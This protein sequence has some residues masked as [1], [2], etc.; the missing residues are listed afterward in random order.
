MTNKR[1]KEKIL[2]IKWSA[3]LGVALYSGLFVL[4]NFCLIKNC[5]DNAPFLQNFSILVWIIATMLFAY[6]Y[7]L[8]LTNRKKVNEVENI[9]SNNIV[10]KE[11]QE[12]NLPEVIALFVIYIPVIVLFVIVI[13]NDTYTQTQVTSDPEFESFGNWANILFGILYISEASKKLFEIKQRLIKQIRK[14]LDLIIILAASI[15]YITYVI[16]FVEVP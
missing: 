6:S 7:W 3:F 8:D 14:L 10:E 4:L 15:T 13:T 16:H 1:A 9:S 11:K 2:K 12:N 5:I